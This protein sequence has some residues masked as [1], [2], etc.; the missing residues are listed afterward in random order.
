MKMLRTF[1]HTR[2]DKIKNEVTHNKVRMTL[3]EDN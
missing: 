2:K 3:N 1:I